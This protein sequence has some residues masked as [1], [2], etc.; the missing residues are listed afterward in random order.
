MSLALPGLRKFSSHEQHALA[1]KLGGRLALN[2]GV[3]H[4]LDDFRWVLKGIASCPTRI[5]ELVP[6]PF[7]SEEYNDVLGL[8]ACGVW[9]LSH[10]LVPRE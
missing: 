5:A 7:S 8:E 9:F 2:R 4:A 6:L 3:H 1:T 10:H